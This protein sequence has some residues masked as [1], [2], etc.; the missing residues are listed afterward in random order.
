MPRCAYCGD[1]ADT[2]DH[3]VPRSYDDTASFGRDKCVPACATCNTMLG[4]VF[5][6]TVGERAA[7]LVRGYR[8]RYR[9]VLRSVAWDDDELAE[10]GYALRKS[11]TA[12]IKIKHDV[13]SKIEHLEFV[14]R[15]MPSIKDVWADADELEETMLVTPDKKQKVPENA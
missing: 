8:W 14:S 1:P 3:V 5:F 7:Y 6:H 10:L 2:L 13:V 4:N 15:T 12:S 11:V 9:K